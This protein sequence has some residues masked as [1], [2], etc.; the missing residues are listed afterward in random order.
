MVGSVGQSRR[1]IGQFFEIS[2]VFL[3]PLGLQT[4]GSVI[5]LHDIPGLRGKGL[6]GSSGGENL[7]PLPVVFMDVDG[8]GESQHGVW[9]ASPGEKV[10]VG[11][12]EGGPE[13]YA[14]EVLGVD[15][16]L[17]G[18]PKVVDGI[19][20][21]FLEEDLV[22]VARTTKDGLEYHHLGGWG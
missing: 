20:G 16:A 8:A 17:V 6:W 19:G 15:V 13:S 3:V 9:G 14:K 22:K 7:I 2:G 18:L 5:G 4:L 11:I 21:G 10:A 12:E 1:T